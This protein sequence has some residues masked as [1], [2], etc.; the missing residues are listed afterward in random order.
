MNTPQLLSPSLS[1]SSTYGNEYIN[2]FP[3]VMLPNYIPTPLPIPS[4]SPSPN[5]IPTP[6][7]VPTYSPQ[8]STPIPLQTL[9]PLP[10]YDKI[11]TSVIETPEETLRKG[12]DV[13]PPYLINKL[14]TNIENQDKPQGAAT[15]GWSAR[16][17]QKGVERT[18]LLNRCGDTAFL[19]PEVKKFPI[20]QACR[21]NNCDCKIDCGGVLAAKIRAKQWGYTEVAEKA[22]YLLDTKCSGK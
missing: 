14:E 13:L 15:R 17:P 20:M 3:K 2:T 18:E 22:Q 16:A 10:Q 4:Y 8:I 9:N 12:K 5:Y 21:D 7:P 6:L 19:L 11:Q 1:P